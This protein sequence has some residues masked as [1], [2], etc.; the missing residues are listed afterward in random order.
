MALSLGILH[1]VEAPLYPIP[2]YLLLLVIH[3]LFAVN[4]WLRR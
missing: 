2:V 1:N 4:E 3:A